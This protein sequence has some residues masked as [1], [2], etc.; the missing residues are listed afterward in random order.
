MKAAWK[1]THP[2]RKPIHS[3]KPRRGP[4]LRNS[5]NDGRSETRYILEAS[6]PPTAP[7]G[8]TRRP[9]ITP[10]H[11]IRPPPPFP[12]S[13]RQ[14]VSLKAIRMAHGGGQ[15]RPSLRSHLIRLDPPETHVGIRQKVGEA[16]CVS[17]TTLCALI[18]R[19]THRLIP[20]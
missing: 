5:R 12:E 1:G 10:A 3:A 15:E 19:K 16:V 6:A 4:G 20:T 8:L 18:L 14:R 9:D 11:P 13:N 2:R 17:K 7:T